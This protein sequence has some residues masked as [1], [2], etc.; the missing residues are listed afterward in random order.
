M[1]MREIWNKGT[2]SQRKRLLEARG[3]HPS[4]ADVSE[5]NDLCKRSG[6]HVKHDFDE[7]HAEWKRRKK[8]F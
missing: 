4:F 8:V 1:S 6:G 2:K 7:L 3:L 5:Y